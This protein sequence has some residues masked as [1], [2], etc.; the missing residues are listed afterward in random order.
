MGIRGKADAKGRIVIPK[1]MRR[2]HDEFLIFRL[3]E[4]IFLRPIEKIDDP[5]ADLEEVAVATDETVLEIK[6]RIRKTLRKGV[7]RDVRRH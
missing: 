7:L 4:G 1:E 3:T 6:R 5:I 2:G